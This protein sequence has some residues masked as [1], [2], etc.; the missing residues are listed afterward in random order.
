MTK[1][2]LLPTLAAIGLGG[3]MTFAIPAL[4]AVAFHSPPEVISVEVGDEATI[5][6]RGA[7]VLVPIEVTCPAG[8]QGFLSTRV[9]QRAGRRIASGNGFTEVTCT[10]STQVVDVLV[11]AQGGGQAFK[12]GTA[13]AEATLSTCG[14]FFF[15]TT[16]SDTETIQIVR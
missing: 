9:T 14:G 2:H 12:K 16:V 13:V 1:R 15:C 11:Q 8:S 6:A 4:P 10:G 5:V 7:A 3:G